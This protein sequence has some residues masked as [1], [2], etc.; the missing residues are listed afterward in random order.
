MPHH[1]WLCWAEW[2]R[3]STQFTQ[4][5]LGTTRELLG[6]P[7]GHSPCS[8]GMQLL[9]VGTLSAH[10][11]VRQGACLGGHNGLC[12]VAVTLWPHHCDSSHGHLVTEQL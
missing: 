5:A 8:R 3:T 9:P 10:P 4:E 1:V 6:S 11:W 12:P 2:G 7:Q